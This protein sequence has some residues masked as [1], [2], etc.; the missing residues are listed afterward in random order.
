MRVK[1][2]KSHKKVLALLLLLVITIGYALI[3]T[4]LK[5]NGGVLLKSNIWDIHWDINSISV[6]E[7]SVTDDA[8]TTSDSGKTLSYTAALEVPG[9][10]YEFTIDAVNAGTVDGMIS[11][12]SIE[13]IIKNGSGEIATLPSYIHIIITYADGSPVEQYHKL[14]K[15]VD[16]NT[17][18]R[19]KYKIRIEYDIDS[20]EKVDE[21]TEYIIEEKIPYIQAD[22]NA[23]S[24]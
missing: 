15:R 23:K 13:P 12:N 14:A 3:S 19:E 20:E 22:K 2:R 4:T 6:T 1:T 7:G 16:T 24:R 11:I 21:D 18:T 17:P 9:D 10:Y 5:I 8:P